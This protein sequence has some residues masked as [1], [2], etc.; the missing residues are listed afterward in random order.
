MSHPPPRTTAETPRTPAPV[1]VSHPA[2][3]RIAQRVLAPLLWWQRIVLRRR[4]PLLPEAGG[5]TH[6]KAG[7]GI[8]RLRLLIVGDSSAAGV[9]VVDQSEAL[10]AQLAQALVPVLASS[11][12]GAGAVSWQ[13]VART[14]LT[15]EGV[16]AMMAAT[17]LQ[18]ADLLITVLGVNDVLSQTPPDKWL[19]TLDAIRGHARHRA[20]VLHTVHC[21]PPRLD[22]LPLLPQ[23]LRWF[24]GHHAARLDTAL[25]RHVRQAHRRSRF[26]LPF[27]PAQESPSEWLASDGFHPNAAL[28]HRWAVAL[29]DHID[30]D[31]AQGALTRAAR[32]S[33]Y[34]GPADSSFSGWGALR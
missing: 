15:A 24:L 3:A 30:L 28:Y 16:L 18:P 5:L 17:K 20:K 11:P 29:A 7:Q 19:R 4:T 32:P 21:A 25:R 8:T 26:V 33:N 31:L 2:L 13:V 1:R 27:D 9:G 6:G 10:A 23:P 22:L 12:L 14:G 34:A